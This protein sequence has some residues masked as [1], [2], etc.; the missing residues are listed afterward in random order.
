MKHAF[1]GKSSGKLSVTFTASDDR[2]LL[3]V[4]DDGLGLPASFD[5]DNS[6]SFGLMLIR[7][8]TKQIEGTIRIEGEKGTKMI[9]EFVK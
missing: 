4:E 9:V 1:V 3:V 7:L 8:F 5:F 6:P 2:G